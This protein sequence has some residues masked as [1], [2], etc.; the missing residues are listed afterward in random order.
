MAKAP[1]ASV[2]G[3]IPSS[4]SSGHRQH[5]AKE[6]RRGVRALCVFGR[7]LR[8]DGRV[9][10]YRQSCLDKQ[11]C[12]RGSPGWCLDVYWGPKGPT[13]PAWSQPAG[14]PCPSPKNPFIHATYPAIS[15]SPL[16]PHAH[17]HRETPTKEKTQTAGGERQQKGPRRPPPPP[18]P[19]PSPPVPPAENW[20]SCCPP[21]LPARQAQGP[22]RTRVGP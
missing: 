8:D 14:A 7:N 4:A 9:Q 15:I 2:W 22:L 6:T 3:R 17:Q 11:K 10:S 12:P 1:R 13:L 16:R 21:A 5:Q 20:G 18:H 19:F